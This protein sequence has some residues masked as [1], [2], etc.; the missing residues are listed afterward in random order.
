MSLAQV[1]ADQS[2]WTWNIMQAS[3][4]LGEMIREDAITSV[5]L[6][7]IRD[8]VSADEL[9]I[10]SLQ[11]SRLESEYGADWLWSNGQ[12]RFLVQAKRLDV[13]TRF[14]LAAYRIDMQQLEL[15]I[16]ASAAVSVQT[17]EA[18]TPVYVFYNSML[19]GKDPVDDGCVA[20]SAE[21]LSKYFTKTGRMGQQTAALSARELYEHLKPVPMYRMFG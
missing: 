10:L 8:Q 18:F 21:L 7:V 12:H 6:A 15:L 19:N 4:Q 14:G 16:N 13:T 11:G 17:Q 1:L 20:I 5:N 9:H 3:A 2:K